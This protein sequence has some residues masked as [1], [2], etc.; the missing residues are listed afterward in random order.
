VTHLTTLESLLYHYFITRKIR[1]DNPDPC[2]NCSRLCFI[3]PVNLEKDFIVTR[4]KDIWGAHSSRLSKIEA[5]FENNFELNA[6][7]LQH[8]S[9]INKKIREAGF[10]ES[11]KIAS[12]GVYGSTTYGV[13]HDKREL[14]IVNGE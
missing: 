4:L 3:L 13:P 2:G 7:L 5:K 14:K 9:R 11:L 6:W 12:A 10:P 1:C 8:R